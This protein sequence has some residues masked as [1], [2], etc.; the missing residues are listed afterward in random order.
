[1][2]CYFFP[3]FQLFC[4]SFFGIQEIQMISYIKHNRKVKDFTVVRPET[5]VCN[6]RKWSLVLP[7]AGQRQQLL[8]GRL[9]EDWLKTFYNL[10]QDEDEPHEKLMLPAEA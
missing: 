10:K 4:F 7:P 8:D 9:E 5:G 6:E 2:F 1:M 3:Q